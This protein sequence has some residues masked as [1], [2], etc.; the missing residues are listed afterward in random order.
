MA[1]FIMDYSGAFVTI[2]CVVWFLWSLCNYLQSK[3]VNHVRVKV[4]TEGC[5]PEQHGD[6]I[7]LK[8]AVDVQYKAGDSLLIPLG[9]AMEVPKGYEVHLLPRSSTFKNYSLMQT[10][11]MGI[12]D[13]DYC[14]DND[15]YKF[16]VVA[17]GTG[18]VHKGDRICQIRLVKVQ[19]KVRF[20]YVS[21]LG[22]TD[23][24]GFGSTG[25]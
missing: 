8:S 23:R 6:W 12:I 10:N 4:I 1:D 21:S 22:N 25:K 17:G 18:M 24:N 11:S 9:V 7:D 14:G 5:E 19:N 16:P 13:H 2:V 20:D 15:E 3:A